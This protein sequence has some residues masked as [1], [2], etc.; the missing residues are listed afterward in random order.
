MLPAFTPKKELSDEEVSKGAPARDSFRKQVLADLESL[1][2]PAMEYYAKVKATSSSKQYKKLVQ[3]ELAWI[4]ANPEL[5]LRQV[6]TRRKQYVESIEQIL[7]QL[8]NQT[9]YGIASFPVKEQLPLAQQFP[10]PKF[11]KQLEDQIKSK[12]QQSSLEEKK[13]QEE[14]RKEVENTSVWDITVDALKYALLTVCVLFLILICLRVGSFAA[15][16]SIYKPAPYR[17]LNFIYGFLFAP[18]L[19]PYYLYREIKGW[20]YEDSNIIPHFEGLLPLVSY[21]PKESLTLGDRI[22][23]FAKTPELCEWSK[24]KQSVELCKKKSV[25]QSDVLKQLQTL[26]PQTPA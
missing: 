18:L 21:L 19:L 1:N 14:K 23:G 12:T 16:D 20:W 25:L 11:R 22:Y 10:I 9:Q 6:N 4:N 17:I 24:C 7:I 15:N 2:D 3:G 13:V 26:Y 8:L 5:S